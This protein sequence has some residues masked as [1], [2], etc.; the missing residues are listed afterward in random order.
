LARAGRRGDKP[1]C[2]ER[3]TAV[4]CSATGCRWRRSAQCLQPDGATDA[5][6][7]QHCLA[8]VFLV[9]GRFAT[10]E[11]GSHAHHQGCVS[12]W[13]LRAGSA[14]SNRS[15]DSTTAGVCVTLKQRPGQLVVR[16]QHSHPIWGVRLR[17]LASKDPRA[18]LLT[19]VER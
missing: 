10:F 5:S 13:Q 19:P 7:C 18:D 3:L 11:R 12:R 15:F 6:D 8:Q 1:W 17:M 9:R 4:I 16:R 14:L 2:V